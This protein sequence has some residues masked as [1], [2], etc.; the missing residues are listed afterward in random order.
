M[1][2]VVVGA[3]GPGNTYSGRTVSW[4]A[5]VFTI[6]GLGATDLPALI[7]SEGAGQFSWASP[8]TRAWAMAQRDDAFGAD[9]TAPAPVIGSPR[10]AGRPFGLKPWMLV[11]AAALL[12]VLGVAI[13]VAM[14][15]P[16]IVGPGPKPG[17]TV[18]NAP[19][20]REDSYTTGQDVPLTVAAAAGMLANDSDSDGDALS[21]R[22]TAGPAH[23]TMTVDSAG[24]FTYTPPAG[25]SGDDYFTYEVTDGREYRSAVVNI[26][27]TSGGGGTT[28][29]GGGGGTG[30]VI[31]PGTYT[32]HVEIAFSM[33]TINLSYMG[34]YGMM[35]NF[36]TKGRFYA[37]SGDAVVGSKTSEFTITAGDLNSH[38]VKKTKAR[39][40]LLNGLVKKLENA[41]WTVTGQGAEWFKV[42]LSK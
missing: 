5:G 41:G 11:V 4:V 38:S 34:P 40:S 23:G 8:E 39:S 6:D 14:Q 31:V 42:Q 21:V 20:A 24:G 1:S 15:S 3:F 29:T 27:V 2:M 28:T 7:A 26:T 25:F 18:N 33:A 36:V 32:E 19:V 37:S 17:N 9:E 12:L 35:N 10:P 16:R 13:A 30:T 22:N